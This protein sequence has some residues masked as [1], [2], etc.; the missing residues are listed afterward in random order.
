MRGQLAV[1]VEHRE[2]LR[3]LFHGGDQG[4]L[5]HAQKVVVEPAGQGHRPLHQGGHLVEQILVQMGP[6]AGVAA[7]QQLQQQQLQQQPQAVFTTGQSPGS[8]AAKARA[9]AQGGAPCGV[10]SDAAINEP[11]CTGPFPGPAGG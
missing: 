7:S 6:A 9:N 4:F 2:V 10:P 3:V 5:G 11:L 1:V 8:T